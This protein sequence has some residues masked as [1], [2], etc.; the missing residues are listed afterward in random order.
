MIRSHRIY[1]IT[2]AVL[3]LCPP[4]ARTKL[5]TK[6]AG[7]FEVS[8]N[9]VKYD[10][11]TSYILTSQERRKQEIEQLRFF[12]D[13]NI[14]DPKLV[15]GT[16]RKGIITQVK[17]DKSTIVDIDGKELPRSRSFTDR[18]SSLRY[19]KK[20]VPPKKPAKW[21]IELRR[22]LKLPP[23]KTPRPQWLYELAPSRL[24][25]ELDAGLIGPDSEKI[26][27]IEG[28]FHVLMAESLEYVDIPFKPTEEWVRIT[29]EYE[30]KVLVAQTTESRFN[31]HIESRPKEIGLTGRISPDTNLPE[32][33]VAK[34][35][36]IG[37]D[38]K[39]IR[40]HHNTA[41]PRLPGSGSGV[42]GGS[43]S[44][45][46]NMKKFRF[47]IA[48]NP[49][50]HKIPFV[51]EDTRLPG[52]DAEANDEKTARTVPRSGRKAQA[53][54]YTPTGPISGTIY[55]QTW[56]NLSWKPGSGADSYD[57]YLGESF[58]DV[59]D[60]VY[61]T[62]HGNQTERAL[63]VG[64]VGFPYPDGLVPGKTYYWRVD[65]VSNSKSNSPRKG[66]V[67]SF[68]I[69]PKTAFDPFPADGAKSVDPNVTLRWT[70]G[71]KAK[72]HTVY[73]GDDSETV[74]NATNGKTQP[75]ETFTPGTLKPGRTYYWRVDEFDVPD[76]YKGKVWSF[77]VNETAESKKISD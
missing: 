72:L 55:R 37:K 20:F 61:G 57:V 56:M 32:R 76:T 66:K 5:K 28:Y 46:G 22:I 60:G 77:T 42:G 29:P 74:T 64:F 31:Y 62:F 7:L 69:A 54:P 63:I 75:R 58:E 48:V 38:G 15:L 44:N 33:F 51:L 10:T 50:H 39:P 12:C 45:L 18:Y 2:V 36:L 65:E 27:R 59:N 25:L 68:T 67:R 73:F 26:S 8:L 9:S 34:H 43:G 6:T 4:T 71:L 16:S 14:A 19:S 23:L 30:I 24:T 1:I 13:V 21:K 17:S 40:S 70:K 49:S 35:Q 53:I 3:V 52:R 47:V 41:N 11:S